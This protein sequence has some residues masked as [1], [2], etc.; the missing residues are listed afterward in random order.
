[1][2]T[3]PIPLVGPTYTSSSLP[4]AAQQTR[5]FYI[6]I[7][8]QA[9][10]I[11]TFRSYPGLT[12]FA[13]TEAGV[14]RGFGKYNN[15]AYAVTDQTLYKISSAG[16]AT[17]IG[18]I[19]GTGQCD[20]QD[21]GVN[22]VITTGETKPYAYDGST[23]TLGT[24]VDLSSSSTVTYINRRVV[25]DGTDNDIIFAD[26]DNPLD[27]NSAN[28]I[29]SDA[30]P[31]ARDTTAVYSFNQ[32]VYAFS[33]EYI[34]PYYNSG[35]GNPP[36]DAITNSAKDVGLGAVHSIA[37]NDDYMY[38]LGADFKVYR[39]YGLTLEPIT[40]AAIGQAIEGYTYPERAK[41]FCYTLQGQNFYHL[42]FPGEETWL[43]SEGAGWTNL[44]TNNTH[45]SHPMNGFVNAYGKRL[46]SDRNSGNIYEL[47]FDVYTNNG[48]TILRERATRS[49]SGKDLG[50]PGARLFFHSLEIVVETG[51]GLISGQGSDPEIMMEYSDDGGNSWSSVRTGKMGQQGDYMPRKKIIWHKLGSAYSRMFRFSVSDPVDVTLISANANVRV[52]RG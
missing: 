48:D 26:L 44:T 29:S 35:V 19:S 30:N 18:T 13:T 47:D 9:N 20:L 39:F 40:N 52:A 16:V 45:D 37:S 2:Q 32:Q 31:N 15:E 36:Y 22:L 41:G 1:M 11:A 51:V 8:Q 27:V 28:V 21:D 42:N 6:E 14:N 12:L 4:V 50:V 23:L 46:V 3:I 17:S 38:F 5:N 49:V 34:Q 33:P 7:G 43:F 25:Y 24:D 10:E